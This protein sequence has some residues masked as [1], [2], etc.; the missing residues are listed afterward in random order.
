[1]IKINM[2]DVVDL[3]LKL[4]RVRHKAI[5]FAQKNTLNSLAFDGMKEARGN[6]AEQMTLRNKYTQS[7]IT[8]DMAR[9]LGDHATLG[10]EAE[11]L[12]TQEAGGTVDPGA[13]QTPT[14]SSEGDNAKPRRKL[15]RGKNRMKNIAL[16]QPRLNGASRAQKASS[17]IWWAVRTKSKYVYFETKRGPAIFRVTGAKYAPRIKMLYDLSESSVRIPRNVW[18]RT[19]HE[20]AMS[21]MPRHYVAAMQK[22][23]DFIK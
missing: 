13:I 10:S 3:E 12:A 18:L 6:V 4:E 19:A 5:P 20:S 1:M 21:R 8:V 17:A 15:A 9:R 11:Y 14:A 16:R 7:S 2:S 22:Q 23:L